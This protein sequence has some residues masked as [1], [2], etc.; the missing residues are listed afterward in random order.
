MGPQGKVRTRSLRVPVTISRAPHQIVMWGF[1]CCR[2]GG[3]RPACQPGPPSHSPVPG[4]AAGP[5]ER[6]PRT[7]DLPAMATGPGSPPAR[8]TPSPTSSRPWTTRPPGVTCY[9]VAS[10][11]RQAVDPRSARGRHPRGHPLHGPGAPWRT[12]LA[13]LDIGALIRGIDVPVLAKGIAQAQ[14]SEGREQRPT[15]PRTCG[16]VGALRVWKTRAS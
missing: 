15:A 10:A 4:L 13:H 7:C 12:A 8:P 3:F 5:L 16:N 1:P 9:L 11:F 6:R 2:L 14:R